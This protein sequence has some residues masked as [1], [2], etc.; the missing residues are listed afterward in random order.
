[1]ELTISTILNGDYGAAAVLIT[2]GALLGKCSLFQLF[3]VASI[4]CFLFALNRA[5]LEHIFKAT[6]D[7]GSMYI[8]IF[9]GFFGLAA[10]FFYQVKAACR[11][12]K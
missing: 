10:Q 11:D 1:L 4:E 8:H 12:D 7:G 9:G 3:G 2:F 6:D 5:I